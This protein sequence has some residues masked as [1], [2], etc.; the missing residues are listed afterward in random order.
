MTF[1][2]RPMAVCVGPPVRNG[3]MRPSSI[4]TSSR[5]MTASRSA[6]GQ[7]SL[8]GGDDDVGVEAPLPAVVLTD[9]GVVPVDAVVGEPEPVGELAADRDRRLC[10]V[11]NSVVRVVEAQSVPVDGG[12][13]VA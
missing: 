2:K 8:A 10:L 1:P 7:A 9:V 5:V 6:G 4:R 12:L 3:V 13:V 11:G